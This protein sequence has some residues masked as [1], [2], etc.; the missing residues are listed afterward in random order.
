MTTISLLFTFHLKGILGTTSATLTTHLG[1]LK[2]QRV[3][4]VD[5]VSANAKGVP[6]KSPDRKFLRPIVDGEN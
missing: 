6:V 3:G 2:R 5:V 1:K 4:L